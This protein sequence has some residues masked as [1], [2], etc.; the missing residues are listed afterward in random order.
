MKAKIEMLVA[1][2]A[3][4]LVV[5]PY[6]CEVLAV[7]ALIDDILTAGCTAGGLIAETQLVGN[8]GDA[9]HV[10]LIAPFENLA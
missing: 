7:G 10:E 3:A 9:H 8:A 4:A 5:A 2:I 1:A 6:L